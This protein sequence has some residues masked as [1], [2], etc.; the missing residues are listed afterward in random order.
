V[1]NTRLKKI[2]KDKAM[3]MYCKCH[4]LG[5]AI[6]ISKDAGL[7]MVFIEMLVND[8]VSIWQRIVN[9]FKYLRDGNDIT[10]ADVLLDKQKIKEFKKFVAKL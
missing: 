4:D 10:N 3:V 6:R 2:G 5:H 8:R 7:E 1:K 9:I